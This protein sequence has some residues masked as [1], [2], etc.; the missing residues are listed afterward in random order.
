MVLVVF[1]FL[2]VKFLMALNAI[3]LIPSPITILS[4][5]IS[6]FLEQNP[7]KYT[8]SKSKIIT[9]S[10]SLSLSLVILVQ[11]SAIFSSLFF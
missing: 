3:I 6:S 9:N 4:I 7:S 1:M 8:K 2:G 11:I 10:A 5:K